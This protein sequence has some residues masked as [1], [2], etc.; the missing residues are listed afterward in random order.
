MGGNVN[1]DRVSTIIPTYND[2]EYLRKAVESIL[3]QKGFDV[4]LEVILV[5][6][7][8]SS[9]PKKVAAEDD[10][11]VYTW[12][13]PEGV[14]AARNHGLDIATGDAIGFCDA[15]DYWLPS[16]LA[17]QLPCLEVGADIVYSD[18]YLLDE[19]TRYLN[20]SLP[21]N[22]A[23]THH[24]NYFR[25]GGIGSRSVMARAACFET[26]RF[27]NNFAAREDPH[28]W[29]RLFAEFDTIARVARPLSVKRR[30]DESL[31]SDVK[32]VYEMEQL[33]I[34]ELVDRYPELEPYR[35]DR[36][37]RA[38]R[39]YAKRCLE[40][41]TNITEA[42]R[43]LWKLLRADGLRSKTGVL[44][45]LAWL[46]RSSQIFYILQRGLWS[47]QGKNQDEIESSREIT[48]GT[49]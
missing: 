14:A 46:P 19:G 36:L 28:L 12:T 37:R 8:D 43:H 38:L 18:E 45:I 15:D 21:I 34:K 10:R 1:I 32:L 24:I 20:N 25:N 48:L 47:V 31:T 16:K 33:E 11:I 44:F 22:D 23:D 42:R 29:T 26:E 13:E 17:S 49:F 9:L 39:N 27:N 2:D 4:E 40:T 5:D 7:G 6:S 35:E 3:H 41:E 30:R